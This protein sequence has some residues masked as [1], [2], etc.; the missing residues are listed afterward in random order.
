M[1][2]IRLL[3]VLFGI[4]NAIPPTCDSSRIWSCATQYLDT[5]NDNQLSLDELNQY[6]LEPPCGYAMYKVT[7]ATALAQCDMNSDGILTYSDMIAP[8]GCFATT[9]L[10]RAMCDE[11]DRCDAYVPGPLG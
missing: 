3:L 5:N 6:I 4:A 8:A 11:C 9:Q 1:L 10:V 7:G 2:F